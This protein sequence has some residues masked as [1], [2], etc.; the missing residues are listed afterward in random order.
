MIPVIHDNSIQNNG[1]SSI[2]P[3]SDSLPG[4][5]SYL[6]PDNTSVRD[7]LTF[8]PFGGI[9]APGQTWLWDINSLQFDETSF[10]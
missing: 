10:L 3:N 6:Q 1:S 9:R 5:M 8:D 7:N 4:L 2:L